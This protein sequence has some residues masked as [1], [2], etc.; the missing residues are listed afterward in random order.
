MMTARNEAVARAI[1]ADA[2]RNERIIAWLRLG[3]SPAIIPDFL[4]ENVSPGLLWMDACIFAYFVVA[5]LA[6]YRWASWPGFKYVIMAA[7]AGVGVYFTIINPDGGDATINFLS[8]GLFGALVV[9]TASIRLSRW[10][11]AYGTGVVI[12]GFVLVLL[13]APPVPL[14]ISAGVIVIILVLGCLSYYV[15]TRLFS[16]V[17]DVTQKAQLARFLSPE[18][19]EL[20]ARDPSLLQL[21]GKRQSVSMLFADIRA[22]SSV[23]EK[24]PPEEVIGFLNDY[25]RTTT[26]V[27]FSHRGT[28][29]KFMGDALMAL[30]GAPLTHPDDADRAVRAAV[31]IMQRVA[32]FNRQKAASGFPPILIGIGVNTDEVIAGNVGTDQRMDY[33]VIGDGVNV[34]ARLEK[35]TKQYDTKVIISQA[36]YD[37]LTDKLGAIPHGEVTIPGRATPIRIYGVPHARLVSQAAPSGMQYGTRARS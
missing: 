26:G 37:R 23:A 6:T 10:A 32:D 9:S 15:M 7:D 13:C 12:L 33:T 18:V 35:L 22:F 19:V 34:A 1:H 31:E 27:I 21:G 29:D 3:L 11:V 14:P 30:F 20:A 2:T 16:L 4:G 17:A 28:L 25:F 36:T 8:L 5:L 24:H